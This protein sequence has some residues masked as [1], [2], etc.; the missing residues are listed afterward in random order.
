MQPGGPILPIA[1]LYG[2]P[3]VTLSQSP[4]D[5][6]RAGGP[7]RLFKDL[8]IVNSDVVAAL[9]NSVLHNLARLDPKNSVWGPYIASLLRFYH[10]KIILTTIKYRSQHA[11]VSRMTTTLYYSLHV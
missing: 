2:T 6:Q 11:D 1:K 4:E 8:V 9:Y 3:Y 10:A 7:S 5:F